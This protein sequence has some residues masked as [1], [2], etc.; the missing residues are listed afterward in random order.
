MNTTDFELFLRQENLAQNTI[1]AYLYAVKDY[2]SH[3]KAILS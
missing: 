3:Y 1:T 2:F